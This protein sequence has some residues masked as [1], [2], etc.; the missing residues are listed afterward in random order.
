MQ[1]GRGEM[2]NGR[3]DFRAG[4]VMILLSAGVTLLFAVVAYA[5]YRTRG[6]TWV[7][8]GMAGA[9][10]I[11]I[12]AIVESLIVRIQLTDDALVVTDLRGRKRYAIADIERIEEAKGGPPAILLKQG[13]WV[14]L[15]SVGSSVGNSVRAWLKQE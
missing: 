6:L 12:G 9:V 14:K 10:I 8:I 5:A 1:H 3:R 2:Y 11:G 4:L 13:R 15:P 7:S